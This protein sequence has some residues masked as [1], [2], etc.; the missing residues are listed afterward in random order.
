LSAARNV[1]LAEATGEIVAYTDADTRVDPDW[2]MFLVQPF[3][4]SNVVG[5]GGPNV[6]PADDPPIAQCIARAPGGPTHV[7]LDDRIAEHVPGC[8]MAFRREALL[9]IGGFN[10]I[11][12]RAGDDVDVCWRLQ[13]RGGKIGFAS[14]ALVWHHHR[15]SI[16]AY[17]RQQLGYGEG[18][19]WLMA[20]HP[21]KFLDGH[22]LWHG[23]IY[24]PLPFVRSLWGT[25]INA[26][27]WGTAAFP[28]VYR[29]DVHPFAFLP[30]SI[31]WQLVSFVLTAIGVVVAALGG[32]PWASTL[33]LASGIVGIAVTIAKNL[34]YALRSEVDNLRGVDPGE[35]G[36]HLR[37]AA[38]RSWYRS[39]LAYLHFIQPLARIRGRIRGVL[40]PPEVALPDARPQTSRG[41]TPSLGEIARA[42]LLIS[43]SVTEDRF[44]SE[45]WTSADR[46]LAQLT[47][48][49]RRSRAVR[50]IEID[51]GWSDDRDVSVF[52]GRWAWLDMRALVEDHGA[53]RSLLRVSTH[54]RPTTFGIVA[55]VA[56]GAAALAA[57]A[58]GLAL[59]QR[60]AGSLGAAVAVGLIGFVIWRTSQAAAI[61]R[62]GVARVTLESGMSSM[63]SGPALAPIVAP[64]LL[65]RYG[66]R[67]ALIFGLMIVSLGASTFIL[68][69]AVTGP[70]IGVK[71]GYGGDYGP[72]I[73]AAIDN[74]GGIVVSPTGEVYFADSNNNT[75]R[76]IDARNN[77]DI[78]P[79]AGNH[80]LGPGFSGDNGPATEAQLDT[81][82][83][84]CIAPDGDIVVADSHNDRIRRVDRPTQV[85]STIAGSGENGYDGDTKL[86][87]DAALNNPSAVACA[88]N[89]NIYIADTFNFRVRMIDARTGLIQT[90]AGDGTAGDPMDVGDG[91]PA[92][93]AHLNTPTDVVL[94]RNGDLYI[95]DMHHNRIRRVDAKTGIISTVAGMGLW[96]NLGDEGPATAAR[97]AS[98]AG[99]AV[100]QEPSGN[101]TLF[102]A[103]SNNGNVRAVGPD[104]IIR[105]LSEQGRVAFG[106]P[107]RV[108]YAPRRGELWVADSSN[109]RL[110][111]LMVPKIAP[112]LVPPQ[113]PAP[114]RRIGG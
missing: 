21:E 111:P 100:V 53:G 40:S 43:G 5:S 86:A 80:D 6:V 10:P 46:V 30:H 64:A 90:V 58:T 1:G 109:D 91:G 50:T 17:W 16:K 82:G 26:G 15:S 9:A 54:L 89:G 36:S 78:E 39:V 56:F 20:H 24:S 2:L 97:L 32:H 34:D 110:V 23:R 45:T 55:A 94:A 3:L 33:L 71:K 104:G 98:P 66:L 42:L 62:R 28:S 96:G 63:P 38:N 18:E 103:D 85:I 22:M 49:L 70:V 59:K 67:S 106:E 108:A 25:K 13:A 68:R 37:R 72:A 47:E 12:L 95:A 79:I 75:I 73:E 29:T 99:I 35:G 101:V 51:E 84:V 77:P 57:A 65:R 27:V 74:P 76:R 31:R 69:E 83:G 88:S 4:N 19:T 11:Y 48:W 41:P 81:P 61:V 8:N 113:R 7:L 14:A 112:S 60:V 52:V 102:I 93:G 87:T 105:N 114:P 92:T 107:T 44:W